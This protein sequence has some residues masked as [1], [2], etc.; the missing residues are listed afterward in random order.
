M[1][2]IKPQGEK[3]SDEE[4]LEA[5][6]LWQNN[7]ENNPV[8]CPKEKCKTKLVGVIEEE[9]FR[10]KCPSCGYIRLMLPV[11]LVNLALDIRIEKRKANKK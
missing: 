4:Q 9:G 8:R 3:L 11:S 1:T 2:E 5:F 7:N 6:N 10:M